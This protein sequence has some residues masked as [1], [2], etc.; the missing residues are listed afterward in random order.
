MNGFTYLD[1]N[2]CR[3]VSRSFVRRESVD[4]CGESHGEEGRLFRKTATA[5]KKKR[6]LGRFLVLLSDSFYKAPAG[7]WLKSI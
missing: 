7:G 5:Q 6:R 3:E 2:S 1:E 4:L